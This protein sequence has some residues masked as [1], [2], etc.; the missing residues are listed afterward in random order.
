MEIECWI[1]EIQILL[2]NFEHRLPRETISSTIK[3]AAETC[4]YKVAPVS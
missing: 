4:S 3:T 2:S 1:F